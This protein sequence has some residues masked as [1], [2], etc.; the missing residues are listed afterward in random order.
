MGREPAERTRPQ[1]QAVRSAWAEWDCQHTPTTHWPEPMESAPMHC[2]TGRPAG[3][4]SR[5]Q[6]QAGA[7]TRG[8]SPPTPGGSKS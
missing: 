5:P 7:M 1:T 6:S 8:A 4:R 2:P 3:W